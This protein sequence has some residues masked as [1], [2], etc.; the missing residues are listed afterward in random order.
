MSAEKA[1]ADRRRQA[2]VQGAW[3]SGPARRSGGGVKQTNKV[4]G[5]DASSAQQKPQVPAANQEFVFDGSV[6]EVLA[7]EAELASKPVTV[8][9]DGDYELS[10]GRNDVKAVV[11]MRQKFLSDA[12]NRR[13]LAELNRLP[14]QQRMGLDQGGQPYQEPRETCWFGRPYTYSHV[15]WEATDDSWPQ[16]LLELKN[17]LAD[18][19]GVE[20]NSVMCNRYRDGKDKIGWHADDEPSLGR[21]PVIASLS[22]GET[23]R[24]MLRRRDCRVQTLRPLI[25]DPI[26]VPLQSGDLLVMRGSLQ[27]DWLHSVPPEYHDKESRI[28]L[29]FRV[30]EHSP[31]EQLCLRPG[32]EDNEN[33]QVTLSARPGQMQAQLCCYR[34]LIVSNSGLVAEASAALDRL[35]WRSAGSCDVA[36]LDLAASQPQELSP[37][38]RLAVALATLTGNA[39]L[40]VGAYARLAAV[41][42]DHGSKHL[43]W[44]EANFGDGGPCQTAET[45]VAVLALGDAKALAQRPL[46]IEKRL[47]SPA[48]GN[49]KSGQIF[50]RPGDAVTLLHGFGADWRYQLG[51]AGR[52]EPHEPA[53]FLF[54]TP[55][56]RDIG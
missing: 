3:N 33:K 7:R 8:D 18:E 55:D 23:R 4:D 27:E 50:L 35:S 46:E 9:K 5:G 43:P 56:Q 34:S 29:T 39:R 54:L 16:V 32:P 24:F 37:L 10:I 44:R 1:K 13:L 47:N 48:Q 12:E 38:A 45:F 15:K 26:T 21:H 14:W 6:S 36:Q 41:R 52:A 49:L 22:F 17:R 2:R 31:N 25:G 19:L 28:N 42:L 53:V 30:I 40:K 20:F 11:Q 51:R